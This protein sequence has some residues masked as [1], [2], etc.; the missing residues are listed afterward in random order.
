M[1][2]HHSQKGTAKAD[3]LTLENCMRGSGELGAFLTSCWATRLQGDPAQDYYGPSLLKNVKQRDFQSEAFEV[4]S[5]PDC[6]LHFIE[7]SSGAVIKMSNAN[8]D[9]KDE[10]ALAILRQNPG[11]SVRDTALKLKEAGIRR[12][13]TWVSDRRYE[14]IQENG[15]KLPGS[16]KTTKACKAVRTKSGRRP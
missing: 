13:K 4:T 6:R 14:M 7:G 16:H 5:S 10:M 15:G 8:K 9:G 2:L 1:V 11:L 3:E 12:G